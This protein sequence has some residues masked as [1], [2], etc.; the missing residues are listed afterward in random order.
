MGGFAAFAVI[1]RKK[2][3]G[4]AVSPQNS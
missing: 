1:Y 2:T 3:A 4:D